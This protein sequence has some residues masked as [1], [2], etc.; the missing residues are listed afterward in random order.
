[1]RELNRA[2]DGALNRIDR[3]EAIGIP[4]NHFSLSPALSFRQWFWLERFG[5][6]PKEKLD[7]DQQWHGFILGHVPTEKVAIQNEIYFSSPRGQIGIRNVVHAES[8]PILLVTLPRHLIRRHDDDLVTGLVAGLQVVGLPREMPRIE[9]DKFKDYV[10]K[11]GSD[12]V[13]N[14]TSA[15]L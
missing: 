1:M 8:W 7:D 11:Y 12:K 9:T 14:Y 4:G 5:L 10:Q 13:T 6:A 2:I 3:H 15:A